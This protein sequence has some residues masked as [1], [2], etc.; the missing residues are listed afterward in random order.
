MDPIHFGT[1]A[2]TLFGIVHAAQAPARSVGVVL[3]NPLGQEAIR[4]Q[5][6]YRQLAMAL[7]KERFSTLRFDYYG[8]GDSAG[9]SNEGTLDQWVDDV[10]TAADELKD[11]AGV[12]RVS[13]IGL[14]L[15][16]TLALRAAQGRAGIDTVVLWDPVLSGAAYLDELRAA[17]REYLERELGHEP[18]VR[19]GR[20]DFATRGEVLGFPLTPQMENAL[21]SLKIANV[22]A[23]ALLNR[24][25][26]V[27]SQSLHKPEVDRLAALAKSFRHEVVSAEQWNS[28]EAMNAATVP[29][30]ILQAL[31]AALT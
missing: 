15:G 19:A 14:R 12:T 25:V 24:L 28:D 31:I 9:E 22:S 4:A 6:A 7:A 18:D 21:L 16:A 13:L 26:L 17:H 5:R 29:T 10:R 11:T 20:R 2:R 30:R 8:T 27:S 23:V 1:S 3:C